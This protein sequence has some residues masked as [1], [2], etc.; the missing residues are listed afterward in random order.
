VLILSYA[1]TNAASIAANLGRSEYSYYFVHKLF[2]PLLGQLGTLVD[3]EEPAREVD[4]LWSA[5]KERGEDC[6]FLCFEPPHKMP[7]GLRCPTLPV[8]AWEFDTIPDE[9][10]AGEQRHDWIRVL[11]QSGQAIVHSTHTAR[12]IGRALGDDFPVSSIP[13][14]VWGRCAALRQRRSPAPGSP[15]S[16]MIEA[17]IVDTR[18][19]PTGAPSSV[20]SPRMLHL[21]GV[22]YTA[23]ANPFDGRK[24]AWGL[25]THFVWA[26][27]DRPDATLL[28]K[29]SHPN[30]AQVMTR[31]LTELERLRPFSCRIV[32][33]H[34]FVSADIYEQLIEA[35]TFMVNS[36][37]AEGQCLPL[38]EFMSCGKPAIAPR[39]TA[40]A[41]YIDRHNA[42]LVD[43]HPEPTIWPHDEREMF[44]ATRDRIDFMSLVRAFQDSF[45][46]ARTDPARY[47]AMSLH[48][49]ERLRMHCADDITLARLRSA[50]GIDPSSSR[51]RSGPPNDG[52]TVARVSR[53]ACG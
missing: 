29:I 10:W 53:P 32:V 27:R 7:L 46:V 37:N 42:F 17:P 51:P 11:R 41:D 45:V 24:S 1:E 16:V 20:G 31:L 35:T 40:M 12:V 28:M 47:R 3:I 2:R 36:S 30:P 25:M 26:L 9:V 52:R 49:V 6:V 34:G 18:D 43:G 5:A 48:A 33:V 44:R 38:M 4:A 21:D 23:V 15:C 50:L 14:P 39:N 13:A 19:P 22:V 8:F